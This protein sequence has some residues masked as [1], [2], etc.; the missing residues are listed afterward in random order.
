MKRPLIQAGNQDRYWKVLNSSDDK[1][2]G[3][4]G[5]FEFDM[6]IYD[7]HEREYAQ[8]AGLISLTS[9]YTSSIKLTLMHGNYNQ[10]EI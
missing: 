10:L 3:Y 2:V 1:F 4:W 5:Y 9:P 8:E 7:E 6:N